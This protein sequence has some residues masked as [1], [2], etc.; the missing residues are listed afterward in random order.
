MVCNSIVSLSRTIRRRFIMAHGYQSGAI[1]RHLFRH[2]VAVIAFGFSVVGLAAVANCQTSQQGVGGTQP[3][4]NL[5]NQWIAVASREAPDGPTLV[6]TPENG[7][8]KTY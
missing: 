3:V 6:V 4:S 5:P 8:A 1:V 7:E 2:Y